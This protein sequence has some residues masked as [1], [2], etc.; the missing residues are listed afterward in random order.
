MEDKE[1]EVFIAVLANGPSTATEIAKLSQVK[2]TTVYIVAEKLLAKG[3]FAQYKAKYG[4]HYAALDP[5]LLTAKADALKEDVVAAMPELLALQ[6]KELHEPSVKYFKGKEGYLSV[7]EDTL[8]GYSYEILY[9]GSA[10]DLNTVISEKYAEKYIAE[11]IKRKISFRQI[12]VNDVFSRKLKGLDSRELRQTKF[13]PPGY[14]IRANT[15]VYQNKVAFFSSGKEMSC[16]LLESRD[17]SE[18]E[19]KKFDLLWS[20]I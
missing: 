18:M 14:E 10:D 15:V 19:R 7:L 3:L 5:K 16:M 4:T 2:R 13:L 8:D 9:F 1:T 20:K 6:K 17:I 11:R 12:V